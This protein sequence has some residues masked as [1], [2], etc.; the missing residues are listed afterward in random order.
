LP[1]DTDLMRW[2]SEFPG[3]WQSG[4]KCNAFMFGAGRNGQLAEA[5]EKERKGLLQLDLQRYGI[6][7]IFVYNLHL[8]CCRCMYNLQYRAKARFWTWRVSGG[9]KLVLKEVNVSSETKHFTY[10]LVYCI[11]FRPVFFL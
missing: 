9:K 11:F 7:Y 3:D 10:F 4:G 6:R 5:G 8:S 1:A 2:W